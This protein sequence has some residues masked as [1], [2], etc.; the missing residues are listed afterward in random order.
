MEQGL[1]KNPLKVEKL[2][3]ERDHKTSS[4][5]NR[6]PTLADLNTNTKS[7]NQSGIFP[8]MKRTVPE[9]TS[10]MPSFSFSPNLSVRLCLGKG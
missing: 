7:T 10:S 8:S 9:N 6:G 2:V 4:D 5:S 3:A 1:F